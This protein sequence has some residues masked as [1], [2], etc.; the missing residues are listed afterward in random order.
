MTIF[1]FEC[2]GLFG[3]PCICGARAR[4]NNRLRMSMIIFMNYFACSLARQF[5]KK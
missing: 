5:A 2:L 4:N 3:A 1:H